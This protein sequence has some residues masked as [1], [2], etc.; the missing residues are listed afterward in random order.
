MPNRRRSKTGSEKRAGKE[1][2]L[3]EPGKTRIGTWSPDRPGARARN[4][5]D[6]DRAL[7]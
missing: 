6:R 4:E 2:L 5:E 7:D 1:G 3:T